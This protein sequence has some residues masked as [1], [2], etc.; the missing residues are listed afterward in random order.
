MKE[1][2]KWWKG[3]EEIILKRKFCENL[4]IFAN[5]LK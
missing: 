2:K 5:D 4:K 3:L 1:N